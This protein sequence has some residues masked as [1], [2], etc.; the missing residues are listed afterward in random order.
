VGKLSPFAVE[1]SEVREQRRH[2]DS[3][4]ED[5]FVWRLSLIRSLDPPVQLDAATASRSWKPVAFLRRT[6]D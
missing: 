1:N 6:A 2:L 4:A 5:F 3:S